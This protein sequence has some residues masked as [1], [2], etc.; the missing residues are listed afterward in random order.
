MKDD[1]KDLFEI[2]CEDEFDLFPVEDP[3]D[4]SSDLFDDAFD[5]WL[6]SMTDL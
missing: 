1:L 3:L 5:A 6:L 4:E 2:R